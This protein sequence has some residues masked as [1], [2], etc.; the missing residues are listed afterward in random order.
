LRTPILGALA[1]ATLITLNLSAARPQSTTIH[2]RPLEARNV[3]IALDLS[4]SMTTSDFNRDGRWATRL[5][6]V[7]SVVS[8]LLKNRSA[9]RVGLVVFGVQAFLQ[10]P[11]TLD[12][13]LLTQMVTSLECGVAGD[14]TAIGDGLGLSVK[15]L[16]GV[17]AKAKSVIL[18]TDGVNNSGNVHPL[19]AAQVAKDLHITVHTIGIG[20][21]QPTASG[22]PEFDEKLL[23]EIASLTGGLYSS[24]SSSEDL[25]VIYQAIE[26]LEMTESDQ[27]SV[28]EIE[29]LFY[30]LALAALVMFMILTAFTR[31]YFLKVPV[32]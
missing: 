27:P 30:P 8:D 10:A 25:R 16:E 17:P 4:R 11:L 7:K 13:A 12:H 3:L 1:L 2:P 15:R 21:D 23:K 14:G 18:I 22:M 20:S 19:K 26:N 24:A 6:G 32:V 28:R 29:E 9:D 5:D 31:S